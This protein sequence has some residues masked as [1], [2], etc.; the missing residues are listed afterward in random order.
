MATK[1]EKSARLAGHKLICQNRR[2]THDYSIEDKLEAGIVLVGT[3]VKACRG[4]KAH[5][6]DAFVQIIRDEAF[7]IAGHIAE[8]THG[9][10][11]NH[12]ANRSRK[13]LLHRK[14][15]DKLSVRLREKGYTAVPLSMYFKDGRVKIEVGVGKGKTGIDR[16]VDIKEREAKREMDRTMRRARR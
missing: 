8:Y 5:L 10:Q 12:E 3:E 14:E 13:L 15:L 7:L 16:R 9:N 11:F 2:A 4:G 1:A 6:N